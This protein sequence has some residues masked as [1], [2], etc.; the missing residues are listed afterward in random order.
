MM[1]YKKL[2]KI[3][4]KG[5]IENIK[6]NVILKKIFNHLNKKKFL[7]IIQ[8]NKTI[9]NKLYLNIDDYKNYS[10]LY[11]NIEIEIIPIP[12]KNK[13]CKFIN[14]PNNKTKSYFHI[15][16]N[17]R[18]EETKVSNININEKIKKI[19]VII[20]HQVIS[21]NGLFKNCNL[22]KYIYFKKF[23][24]NNINNMSYMFA[25]C[26]SLK[27][28]DLSNFN[29]ENVKDM[30]FM[31]WKCKSLKEINLSNFNTNNV[32]Y[33]S[34]MF[35][36]C[37]SLKELDLSNF[38]TNNLIDMKNMFDGCSSLEKL[39]VSSI[40]I[41]NN[42]KL[43]NSFHFSIFNFFNSYDKNVVD[44]FKKNTLCLSLKE[45]I[46]LPDI[47]KKY[48]INCNNNFSIFKSLSYY[49]IIFCFIILIIIFYI[50]K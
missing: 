10:E 35:N 17:N 1:D 44:N 50:F 39:K 42:N 41:I 28:I 21:L 19:K 8:I 15:Y 33:M 18:K 38:N 26:I 48:I 3:K 4:L 9:Q 43:N 16:I 7:Q 47:N 34:R 40:K 13:F 12:I 46:I 25:E 2:K 36:G 27:K 31:F 24:R 20:N 14:I 37:S 45:I 6:N 5:I 30:S 29:T 49:N 22:I 32:L 23:S 11:S